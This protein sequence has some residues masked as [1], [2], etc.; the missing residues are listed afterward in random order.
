[1][2]L[3]LLKTLKWFRWLQDLM[4]TPFKMAEKLM[5]PREKWLVKNKKRAF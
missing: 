1:M 3:N 4:F 2:T 5:D